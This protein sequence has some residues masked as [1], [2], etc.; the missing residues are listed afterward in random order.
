MGLFNKLKKFFSKILK[1]NNNL[2]SLGEKEKVE[3]FPIFHKDNNFKPYEAIKFPENEL[4]SFSESENVLDTNS[5]VSVEK[6]KHNLKILMKNAKEKGKVDKFMLIREDNFFPT[7]WEWRVLSKNTNLEKTCT[8]L[9]YELRKAYALE[10]SGINPYTQI[11][12]IKIPNIS[13][14]QETLALSQVDKNFGSV[15]LQSRFRSTKH[16]TINT[17]L[18]VTGNYNFVT[19][20]RDYIIIDNISSF[21]SSKYGYSVSYHDAYLDISH[22]SLPISK[23]AV[24]LINEEKYNKIISDEK[25]ASELSQRRVVRFKGDTFVAINM[26][27]TEMG[28][29]PSKIGGRYANYD[30]EIMDILD[31][32]MRALAEKNDLF[33]DKSHGGKLKPDGGHFSNYYDDKNNDYEKGV[34][35]FITFLR[36]KFPEQAELFPDNLSLT[37]S[38]SKIIVEKIGVTNLSIAIS[39]YNKLANDRVKN[40]LEEYKKDRKNITP[41]IHQKFIETV[42]L[43]NDF[44]KNNVKYESYEEKMEIEDTIMK[45][46][47][48]ETVSEQLQATEIIW[49]LLP[50]KTFS[51][52]NMKNL[53]ENAIKK[54]ITPEQVA[55]SEH[56][57]YKENHDFQNKGVIIND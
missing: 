51:K 29:L 53:I 18:E 39:E 45:F 25:V 49:K 30:E 16:F 9:S 50:N 48:G 13:Q 42:S 21:L 5:I 17:P 41:E 20:N 26:I 28:A 46:I 19:K 32:S 14:E 23:E 31:S 44:Y 40:T 22:E 8:P 4:V 24:V 55:D 57:E 15:L 3:Q 34:K 33:F 12:G 27:L 54:G 43:I 35:E 1:I 6:F 38:N 7:D 56:I 2:N 47:Q 52:V 10:Q 36:Q 11:N 37:Q